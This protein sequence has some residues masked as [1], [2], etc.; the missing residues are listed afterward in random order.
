MTRHQRV[1]S[2]FY[3]LS[4][5][6]STTKENDPHPRHLLDTLFDGDRREIQ[7]L[8]LGLCQLPPFTDRARLVSKV[9]PGRLDDV[10]LRTGLVDSCEDGR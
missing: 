9:A 4:R 3:P 8:Q 1:L 6:S 10:E 7:L 2:S 5:A